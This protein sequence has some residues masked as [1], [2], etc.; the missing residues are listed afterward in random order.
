MNTKDKNQNESYFQVLREINSN[1][2]NSQRKL[3]SSLG[4]SLGKLNYCINELKKKGYVKVENF[5]KN[6]NKINY[7]YLLT[8][9]G[10]AHK[11]RLTLNFMK[12]KFKEYDQLRKEIENL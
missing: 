12:Q 2:K 4:M 11:T 3:A 7:V 6:P 8:P 1:P 10:I 9:K 5:K